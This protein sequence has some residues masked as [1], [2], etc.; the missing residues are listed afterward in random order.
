MLAIDR[1]KFFHTDRT[2]MSSSKLFSIT[3]LWFQMSIKKKKNN[4]GNNWQKETAK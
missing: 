4:S 2:Q 1:S 3:R